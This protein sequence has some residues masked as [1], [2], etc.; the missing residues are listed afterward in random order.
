MGKTIHQG[1]NIKCFREML[2]IKQ[3]YLANELGEGWSQRKISILEQ[4]EEID[5]EILAKIAQA[6]KLPTEAIKQFDTEMALQ[7]LNEY[8]QEV[9]RMGNFYDFNKSGQVYFS[10]IISLYERML[11]IEHEKNELLLRLINGTR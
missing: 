10:K 5:K 7:N 3:E 9:P 8:F 1:K 4:K 2:N 11:D 6:L